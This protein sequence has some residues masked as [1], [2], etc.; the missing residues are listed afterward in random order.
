MISSVFV[1]L[2]IYRGVAKINENHDF[3]H[4]PPPLCLL[5]SILK[6]LVL[7]LDSIS[8]LTLTIS[9]IHNPLTNIPQY[10]KL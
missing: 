1:H 9:F 10:A 5:I 6:N 4:P 8:V 7:L 2:L 3:A